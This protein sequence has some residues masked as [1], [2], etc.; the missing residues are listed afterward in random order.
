MSKGNHSRR[1]ANGRKSPVARVLNQVHRPQTHRS[2]KDYRRERL[3]VRD[4]A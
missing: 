3:N 1:V 2:A 4:Y